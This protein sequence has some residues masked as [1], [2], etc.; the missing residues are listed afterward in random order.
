ML[1][2][3]SS[4]PLV[5][6]SALVR[7]LD[8]GSLA[9]ERQDKVCFDLVYKTQARKL[10]KPSPSPL[11]HSVRSCA[12]LRFFTSSFKSSRL[13]VPFLF[14]AILLSSISRSWCGKRLVYLKH[15]HIPCCFFHV[16]EHLC[17]VSVAGMN[18]HHDQEHLGVKG[19]ILLRLHRTVRP[20]RQS[21]RSSRQEPGAGAEAEVTEKHCKLA[22]PPRLAQPAVLYT[23]SHLPWV[24]PPS[25]VQ[26][27]S[28]Q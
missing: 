23:Q 2:A 26:T 11:S 8:S 14:C 18:Q 4:V 12:L 1:P 19:F 7:V 21:G 6:L 22:G 3:T 13:E 10:L 27:L 20:G 24:A 9:L 15:L 25:V 16:S 5:L 28:L 17:C